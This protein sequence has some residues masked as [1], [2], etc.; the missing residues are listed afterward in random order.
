MRTGPV[1]VKH[2]AGAGLTIRTGDC[3]PDIVY[4]MSAV[5]RSFSPLVVR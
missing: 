3:P 4:S 5:H 2:E 1:D